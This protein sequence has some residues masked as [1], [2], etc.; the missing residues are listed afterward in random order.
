[1]HPQENT[2][3]KEIEKKKIIEFVKANGKI[4]RSETMELLD[5]GDYKAKQLLNELTKT[6]L[7][8]VEKGKYTYYTLKK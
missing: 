1:M 3:K 5:C 8:R 2:R 7:E 6:D 4:R